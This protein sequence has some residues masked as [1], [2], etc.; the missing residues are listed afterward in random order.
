MKRASIHPS[1]MSSAMNPLA[2]RCRFLIRP[3]LL[4]CTFAPLHGEEYRPGP[5][6]CWASCVA[7]VAAT[8]KGPGNI[9]A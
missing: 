6:V 7:A 8:Y 4:I 1:T 5:L 3:Q 9:N 2:K